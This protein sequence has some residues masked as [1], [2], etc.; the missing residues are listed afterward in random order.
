MQSE[1]DLLKQRIPEL[2]AEKAE[3][4][5][6]NAEREAENVELKAR[7][8]K[9]EQTAEKNT[10]LKD[11]ITKL[12]QKQIQIITNEQEASSTKDISPHIESHSYEEKDII[13]DDSAET[14]HKERISSE[15]R[16]RNRKK[17]LQGS[18]N[19]ST[20]S[21]TSTM[22]TPESLDPKTVKKLWDQNQH[23]SQDKTSQSHKKKGTEN[24]AQVIA[25]GIQDNVISDESETRSFVSS[26]HMT[27]I[28]ATARRQNSDT[29][30][31]LDLAQLFDKATN[32][33]Y[34][35][36]KANQEETL[37]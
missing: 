2:E 36:T 1:I 7:I 5:A 26:N 35:A 21:E 10:E 8:A 6:K 33:E 18:H 15:I 9:L 28:S 16:E 30:S 34:Y 19:N 25:D 12:E 22:S 11:R 20:Q 14:I 31:L 17:K 32:A 29:I 23:K 4:E 13:D 27:E 3:L 24:I 37:C